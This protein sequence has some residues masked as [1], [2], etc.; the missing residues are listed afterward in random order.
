MMRHSKAS[1]TTDIYMQS[2]EP[3]VRSTVDSIY[4]ELSRKAGGPTKPSSTAGAK[5]KPAEENSL[6]S[7]EK[8]ATSTQTMPAQEAPA[9]PA[10]GVALEFAAKMRPN[11]GREVLLNA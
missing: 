8:V 10:R 6:D 4:R 3:E 9:K 11:R 5:G 2:L 7:G 1:T